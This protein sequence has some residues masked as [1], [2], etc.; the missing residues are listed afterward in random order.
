ML[1]KTLNNIASKILDSELDRKH[2]AVGL[3]NMQALFNSVISGNQNSLDP[4]EMGKRTVFRNV[5]K[6]GEHYRAN[7]FYGI[8]Q[9]LKGYSGYSGKVCACIEHG[10]YFGSYINPREALDSGLPA[11]ITFG[12]MRKYHLEKVS[13]LQIIPIGPY[14]QYAKSYYSSDEESEIKE[15]LGRTLLV[16]PQHSSLEA[17]AGYDKNHFFEQVEAIRQREHFDSVIINAYYRDLNSNLAEVCGG[18][19]YIIS[20]AG[21]QTDPLFLSRLKS[22]IHL[23]DYTVS[24]AVGTHVGYCIA[25]NKPHAILGDS[26]IIPKGVDVSFSIERQRD[27]DTLEQAFKDS[28]EGITR[29]Q[30]ELCNYYWGNDIKLSKQ[31][32]NSMLAEC[33]LRFMEKTTSRNHDGRQN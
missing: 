18:H 15:R 27:F 19:G 7:A 13:P 4:F 22:I 26:K 25:L 23:A 16:F 29:Q 30:I 10:V 21:H 32:M 5:E 1:R 12:P 33:E 2:L 17:L 8:S 9:S 6:C 11:V 14:I 3:Y 20:C 31:E 24:A 28:S